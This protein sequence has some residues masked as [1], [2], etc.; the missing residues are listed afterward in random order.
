MEHLYTEVTRALA[1]AEPEFGTL[2]SSSPYLLIERFLLSRSIP[3]E[4]K[5]FINGTRVYR[6]H[7]SHAHLLPLDRLERR[8]IPTRV[9]TFL[10][11]PLDPTEG[12][13]AVHEVWLPV[14]P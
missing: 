13:K 12:I 5:D 9:A 1:T 7:N 4:K 6:V 14:G 8:F 2:W 10:M 3:G 11:L